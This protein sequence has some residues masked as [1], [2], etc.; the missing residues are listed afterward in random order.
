MYIL[1]IEI[2]LND[3]TALQSWAVAL[4]VNKLSTKDNVEVN[5]TTVKN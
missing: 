3:A 2:T 5:V 1:E 4:T